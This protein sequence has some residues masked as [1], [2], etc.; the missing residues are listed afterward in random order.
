MLTQKIKAADKE[1]SEEE[2]AEDRAFF[3]E[4]VWVVRVNLD[5]P[6]RGRSRNLDFGFA[7]DAPVKLRNFG[8]V[9][10]S[11]EDFCIWRFFSEK[12]QIEIL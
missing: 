11:M 10:T 3:R 12:E 4:E 8:F 1:K 2:K 6:A 7:G 9:R 5:H